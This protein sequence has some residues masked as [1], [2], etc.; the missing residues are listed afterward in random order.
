MFASYYAG[1]RAYYVLSFD[2]LQVYDS[3]SYYIW[4]CDHFLLNESKVEKTVSNVLFVK[5]VSDN[6]NTRAGFK[7]EYEQGM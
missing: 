7:L 4:Y 6:V 2:N 5:F 3:E 1:K